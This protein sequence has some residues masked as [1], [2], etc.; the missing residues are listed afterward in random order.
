MARVFSQ[1]H[2]STSVGNV[3]ISSLG[4]ESVYQNWQSSKTECFAG[5]S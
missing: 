2:S 5:V 1:K 4:I 3:G